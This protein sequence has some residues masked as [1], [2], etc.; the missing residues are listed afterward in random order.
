MA[1]KKRKFRVWS[2]QKL[3]LKVILFP[4]K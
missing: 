2:Q 3:G 4:R 1:S